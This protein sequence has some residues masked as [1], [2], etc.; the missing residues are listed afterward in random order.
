MKQHKFSSRPE[1]AAGAVKRLKDAHQGGLAF[2]MSGGDDCGG[3]FCHCHA[4]TSHR[5]E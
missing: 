4:I 5:P 1:L 2:V 3:G